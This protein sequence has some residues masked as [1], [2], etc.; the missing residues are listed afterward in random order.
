MGISNKPLP[1]IP[2]LIKAG[3]SRAPLDLVAIL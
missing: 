1:A 3:R 2:D